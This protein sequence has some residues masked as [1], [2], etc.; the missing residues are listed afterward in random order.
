M[1]NE[2]DIGLHAWLLTR[3]S[4]EHVLSCTSHLQLSTRA[5]KGWEGNPPPV[6][7]L[8]RSHPGKVGLAGC[9]F[10]LEFPTPCHG[11]RMTPN[12][13]ALQVT[14]GPAVIGPRQVDTSRP[15]LAVLE[16]TLQIR[17]CYKQHPA[18][19]YRNGG[20]IWRLVCT[21]G[22]QAVWDAIC[23]CN[24]IPIGRCCLIM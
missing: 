16:F 11:P 3:R 20:T 7:Q 17:P 24:C 22:G 5:I 1:I 12:K 2:D 23:T 13:I 4:C 10:P 15:F 19:H 18:D 9:G 8:S 14:Y 6:L 21:H